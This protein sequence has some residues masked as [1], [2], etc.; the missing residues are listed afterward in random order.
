MRIAEVICLEDLDELNF[1][2]LHL[3]LDAS[4]D[5]VSST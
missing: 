5:G 2:R 1:D 3:R 4:H